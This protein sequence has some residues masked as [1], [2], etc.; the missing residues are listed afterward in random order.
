[1]KTVR[2]LLFTMAAIGFVLVVSTPPNSQADSSQ[3]GWYT[4]DQA[5]NGH[6]LFNNYCAQC[7]MPDLT[8]AM[9]PAL[10]GNQFL[11]SWGTL[12]DLITFEHKNMPANSPGTLSNKDLA[13]I[14][15]YIL[16]KNGFPAGSSPLVIGAGNTRALKP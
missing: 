8:G 12:A 15:A 14:T 7:H 9:G 5:N 3:E 4:A 16:M 2:Y 13:E 6:Q 1:M 11:S 10:V